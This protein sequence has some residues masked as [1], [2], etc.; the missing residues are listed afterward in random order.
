MVIVGNLKPVSR[1][2]K[3]EMEHVLGTR[4]PV[5]PVKDAPVVPDVVNGKK[6]GCVQEMTRANRVHGDE[7]SIGR[8]AET[9]R[10]ALRPGSERAPAGFDA[11]ERVGSA[12]PGSRGGIYPPAGFRAMLGIL[13]TRDEFHALQSVERNLRRESFALLVRDGEAVD[14]VTHLGV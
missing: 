4:L 3:I 14:Y 1:G 13:G 7:V 5:K 2:K 6:L 9:E 11:S 12:E 10:G 8:G